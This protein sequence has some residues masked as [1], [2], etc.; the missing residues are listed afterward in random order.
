MAAKGLARDTR[1]RWALEEAGLACEVR[2]V[3]F[4]DEGTSASGAASVNLHRPVAAVNYICGRQA[5]KLR[6][7]LRLTDC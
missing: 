7:H 4:R 1:V 5:A 2:L 6:F 3:S